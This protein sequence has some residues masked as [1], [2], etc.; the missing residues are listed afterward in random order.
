MSTPE[1]G[2]HDWQPTHT[3]TGIVLAVTGLVVA[4]LLWQVDDVTRPVALGI[5]GA[6]L[7]TVS[8][9]L[10]SQDRAE[11]V[12]RPLVSILTLPVAIGL[13][14][15][16][17]LVTL[18]LA[19][20]FFPVP[21]PS[22]FSTT[23]LLIVGHAGVVFGSV[24]AVLGA[25]L[26]V[27][28]II[29][30]TTLRR[31]GRV[32][33]VTALVPGVVCAGL[34]AEVVLSEQEGPFTAGF[35]VLGLL[36]SWL[37]ATDSGGLPLAGFLFTVALTLTGVLWSVA[38][39]PVA[40]A[41]NSQV[42][43]NRVRRLKIHLIQLWAVT[44]VLHLVALALELSQSEAELAALLGSSLYELCIGV[45]TASTLRVLLLGVLFLTVVA[46]IAGTITRRLA[47]QSTRELSRI[48]GPLAGG[49]FITLVAA[50]VAEHVYDMLLELILQS[51]PPE[52][53]SNVGTMATE[54]VA[55][56][57]EELFIILLALALVVVTLCFITALRV[58]L[59][60]A[61]LS[62]ETPASSLASAGLF[63]GVVS[64]ATVDAP[65]WLVLGGVLASLLIWDVGRFGST[66]GREIGA[67]T[68]TRD[69]ELVHAGATTGVGVVGAVG[70]VVL[71]SSE[72]WTLPSPTT[73]TA[74]V[75]LAVGLIC[76]AIALR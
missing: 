44:L 61:V 25:T 62:A 33:F 50:F 72:V 76:F 23:A 40:E 41:V 66:L 29:T 5:V 7:F 48:A 73:S 70:A 22:L 75:A 3:S 14:G 63:I 15:S 54:A 32:T 56:Y 68:A 36:W 38:A 2:T 1:T 27:R 46:A 11:T 51:F 74:L 31:Y 12:A 17:G 19:S 21:S 52:T 10:L 60:F 4:A 35:D 8:C 28:T 71:A 67:S 64:A 43:G 18:L 55:L 65:T 34:V 16:A 49:S 26:G 13:F 30:P 53:E 59:F 57:G 58:A 6:V 45:A 37:L 47:R 20:Q 24:L 39:L 42:A 69:T 9:W